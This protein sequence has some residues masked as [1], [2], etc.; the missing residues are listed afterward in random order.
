CEPH[1]DHWHCPESVPKPRTPPPSRASAENTSTADSITFIAGL[2]AAIA[3][4]PHKD[5]WHC[6]EGV[7]EPTT[8][9]SSST[10]SSKGDTVPSAGTH[11]AE[12]AEGSASSLSAMGV[13]SVLVVVMGKFFI[14]Y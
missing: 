13:F 9:P 2:L 3:C 6:P 4:E 1:G 10:A 5:H 11:T 8:P 12:L 14:Y 7:P